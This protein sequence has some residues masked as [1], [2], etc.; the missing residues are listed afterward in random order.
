VTLQLSD[1]VSKVDLPIHYHVS[2]IRSGTKLCIL[3]DEEDIVNPFGFLQSSL[4]QHSDK[5]SSSDRQSLKGPQ[6][7]IHCLKEPKQFENVS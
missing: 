6:D 5:M 2:C 1:Q 4:S 3:N 7:G